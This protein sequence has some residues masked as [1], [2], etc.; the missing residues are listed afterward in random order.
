MRI[1]TAFLLL[2]T[3]TFAW[4]ASAGDAIED[5]QKATLGNLNRPERLEWLQD[6]GFGMFIHWS[7][8]GQLGGDIS[9][10]VADADDKTLNW[11]FHELPKT[12]NPTRYDPTH[13]M[14][15]A[16]L[17]GMRYAMFTTK[18][19]NGFCWWDTATTDYN[20]MKTP[21]GR[22][23]VKQYTDA[24]RA[25]GLGVG[26]YYSPEDF[27]FLHDHG[28]PVTRPTPPMDASLMAK[29]K[30]LIRTQ[31]RE[32]MTRYGTIDLLFIDGFQ[33]KL[34]RAEGWRCNPNLLVTRGALATPEQHLPGQALPGAWESNITMGFQ[35]PYRPTGEVYKSSAKLLELLVE[36]RA[37]GGALLLN[38][39]PMPNGELPI[40]QEGRLRDLALWHAFNGESIH[41]TR[42]WIVTNEDTI[43]FTRRKDTTTDD[44]TIYAIM[45]N[46]S[47]WQ[48]GQ[49]RTITLHSAQATDRTRI[50]FLGQNEKT[51]EYQPK[52]DAS[53]TW[54][55]T[56]QGLTI[57]AMRTLRFYTA[58]EYANPMV[59]KL[60]HVKAA[61][62]PPAV[63]TEKPISTGDGSLTLHGKLLD[64]GKA[65]EVEVGFEYQEYLGFH[66]VLANDTWTRT[67]LI[68]KD[69]LGD[70]KLDVA[71][72]SSGKSYRVRAV[73]VHPKIIMRGD[74]QK[75]S[76]R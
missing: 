16:K 50:T 60:E 41:D 4:S 63:N 72:L 49:R 30:E 22:D 55:Q 51:L 29:Y 25:A 11:Y 44:A 64:L 26:I 52:A 42:P 27:K 23:V 43:W 59:L 36:T 47:D 37:K 58:G 48:R 7:V 45:T 69:S 38:V 71:G 18:H 3:A 70:F 9:H 20:V 66:E 14:A 76:V 28:L 6:A 21:Y 32:L 65:A 24:A 10:V 57:S 2:L 74:F 56:S 13:W 8:D 68:K 46:V 75:V 67:A 34:C 54:K 31:T 35:W 40:E 53:T 17:A 15:L 62:E 73:V 5:D 12:L 1:F 61:L 19:H 33:S 39:G